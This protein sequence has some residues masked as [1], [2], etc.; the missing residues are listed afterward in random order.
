MKIYR[1]NQAEFRLWRDRALRTE[2]TNKIHADRGTT[3][4]RAPS[5]VIL[6]TARGTTERIP[7]ERARFRGAHHAVSP[8]ECVCRE[9][10]KPAGKEDQHH[11]ICG[12]KSGWESQLAHDPDLPRERSVMTGATPISRKPKPPAAPVVDVVPLELEARASESPPAIVA[13][14]AARPEEPR[15][16]TT[17][18]VPTV[19]VAPVSVLPPA[20]LRARVLGPAPDPVDCAC[21]D[22][23]GAEPDNH[24]RIC[25]FRERWEREHN[26][27]APL[28]VALETGEVVREA[29]AEEAE[30]SKV[31]SHEDG[32]GAIE[33]SDGRLYYVR[34]P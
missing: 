7:I 31:K 15:P 23:A 6:G 30:A 10:Q 27:P 4:V 16:P 33:L 14:T 8:G 24:H 29:T 2:L 22:W 26:I 34:L 19:T 12:L 28:L 1:L 25:E 3:Q 17:H 5:G 32:V 20:S 21:H 11:P 13:P 18:H 9:W